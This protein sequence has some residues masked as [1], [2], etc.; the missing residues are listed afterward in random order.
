MSLCTVSGVFLNPNSAAV[1]GATVRFNISNPVLD[2][3]GNALVPQEFSTTTAADG[4]WS[5][6]I[7]QN[8]SGTLVLDLI[9]STTAPVTKYQFS[10]VIPSAST[11]TFASCWA[12]GL[13][14]ASQN[15]VIPLTFSVIAGQL[16]ATQLPTLSQD[17]TVNPSGAVTV[18]SAGGGSG[19]FAAGAITSGAIDANG[20]ILQRNG[21]GVAIGKIWNDS[22]LYSVQ[23]DSANV[24]GLEL[25]S[26]GASQYIRVVTNAGEAMRVNSLGDVGIGTTTPS[27]STGYGTLDLSGSNGGNLEFFKAGSFKGSVYNDSANLNVTTATGDLVIFTNSSSNEMMRVS[28]AGSITLGR[29]TSAQHSVNS[30]VKTNGAQAGTLTNTPTAGNPAGFLQITI[31]GTTSYIPYWQ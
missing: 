14:F 21:G 29:G 13:Q 20:N 24:N 4:S 1:S 6:A 12:D 23:A 17:A 22:G 19:T 5:L 28:N 7:T 11:S 18:V 25:S 15:T 2:V 16:V 26:T 10:L 27:H 30:T 8:V 31:N 9:P 3:S